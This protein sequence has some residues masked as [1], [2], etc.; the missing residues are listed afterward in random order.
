MLEFKVGELSV[1]C[2][3]WQ[4]PKRLQT[5]YTSAFCQSVSLYHK[6]FRFSKQKPHKYP[7]QIRCQ[8]LDL[9]NNPWPA[10]QVRDL[11]FNKTNCLRDLDSLRHF[12]LRFGLWHGDGQYAVLHL[13]RNLVA[14]HIIR[15]CVVLLVVR[16]DT[17]RTHKLSWCRAL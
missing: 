6:I 9:S 10:K 11:L 15:Q 7:K 17:P 5:L 13:G 16:N 8:S 1:S 12:L 14:D 3:S 4:S 2:Q